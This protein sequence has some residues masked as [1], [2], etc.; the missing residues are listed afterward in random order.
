MAFA[1]ITKGTAFTEITG[2][3]SKDLATNEEK[4]NIINEMGDLLTQY[5]K[6]LEHTQQ[7]ERN[8]RNSGQDR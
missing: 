8:T 5:T 2:I 4:A 3:S 1:E 6:T 7:S